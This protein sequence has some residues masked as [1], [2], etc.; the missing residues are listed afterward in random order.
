MTTL[1]TYLD[2]PMGPLLV[3]ANAG[4]EH[5]TLIDFQDGPRA[6]SPEPD[7]KSVRRP[8][9]PLARQLE[10]YF[11]GKLRDFDV[12][13]APEGTDFQRRVWRTLRTIAYGRTA[14]YGDIAR[15]IRCPGASR[16][17]GA[18][19]R[20]NPLPILIPCH[21]VIGHSGAL[22][23]FGAGLPIKRA[24]LTLEGIDV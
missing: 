11:R 21:R 19:N 2:S 7:W 17:V 8:F 12:P 13:I 1:Y 22:V 23:G 20:G 18:A 16:A 24:L 3:A 15:R 14:S 9:S 10:A 4:T 6:R 5:I